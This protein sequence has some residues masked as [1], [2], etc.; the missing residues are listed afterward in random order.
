MASKA[1][2]ARLLTSGVSNSDTPH[3]TEILSSQ[4]IFTEDSG[5]NVDH[6]TQ[7]N[8]SGDE[9]I[10][11]DKSIIMSLNTGEK[12]SQPNDEKPTGDETSDE[13]A[14]HENDEDYE[15]NSER[16]KAASPEIVQEEDRPATE[17]KPEAEEASDPH[18]DGSS[19]WGQIHQRKS[20]VSRDEQASDDPDQ[21]S[22][23]VGNSD[24]GKIHKGKSVVSGDEQASD[25]IDEGEDEMSDNDREAM[26]TNPDTY[27]KKSTTQ[28]TASSPSITRKS[29]RGAKKSFVSYSYPETKIFGKKRRRNEA[30]ED[31]SGTKDNPIDVELYTSIWEPAPIQQPKSVSPSLICNFGCQP[32]FFASF[33]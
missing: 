30:D 20:A 21:N 33:R 26:D 8:F 15:D 22:D 12:K 31:N 7:E 24:G 32:F 11:N 17:D 6:D 18:S 14:D 1:G 5:M 28:N 10:G 29:D 23:D 2:Q 4:D 13:D 27:G 16:Q 9:G 19:D 25:G 3:I